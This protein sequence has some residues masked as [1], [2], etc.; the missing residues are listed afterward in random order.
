MVFRAIRQRGASIAPTR[1]R[2]WFYVGCP[3]DASD[4]MS[5]R[6]VHRAQSSLIVRHTFP[7]YFQ[8]AE[9]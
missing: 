5:P 4:R 8:S 6:P 3:I 9:T 7:G 1:P 2:P